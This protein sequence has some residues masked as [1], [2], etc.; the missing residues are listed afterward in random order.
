VKWMKSEPNWSSLLVVLC[1]W[2][3][4]SV[5]HVSAVEVD[6]GPDQVVAMNDLADPNSLVDPNL[7]DPTHPSWPVPFATDPNS[8][9]EPRP[10]TVRLDGSDPCCTIAL[11][12]GNDAVGKDSH[13]IQK[14]ASDG[15]NK[16]W[17]IRN[18]VD[19][20]DSQIA[21]MI[22]SGFSGAGA[23]YM[24][25]AYIPAIQWTHLALT[26]DGAL[27]KVYVNGVQVLSRSVNRA[28]FSPGD[29][30]TPMVIG[31]RWNDESRFFM[32][33]IDEVRI[34]DYALTP[35]ALSALYQAEGGE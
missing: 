26:Y 5:G 1:L 20:A 12:V 9:I 21:V 25:D 15:S 2:L 24:T 11:W 28:S 17:M 29:L 32:G 31:C 6:A 3:G 14:W 10:V 30:V 22:G 23:Y 7:L 35:E 8:P 33:A 19:T 16:G 4:V 34:Y 18:R 13:I 27:L